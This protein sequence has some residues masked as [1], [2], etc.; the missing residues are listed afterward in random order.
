MGSARK[1]PAG[2]TDEER[3]A[4]RERAG[5]LKAKIGALV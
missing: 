3:A 5:E 4:M 2:F 1:K